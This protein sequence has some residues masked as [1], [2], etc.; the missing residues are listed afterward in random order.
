ITAARDL[1][2]GLIGVD[3]NEFEEKREVHRLSSGLQ[4]EQGRDK[5][6]SSTSPD[7]AEKSDSS[8]VMVDTAGDM[9]D[10][11]DEDK[12]V[13]ER[14]I[15]GQGEGK[16][17][18]FSKWLLV[19]AFTR[20]LRNPPGMYAVIDTSGGKTSDYSEAPRHGTVPTTCEHE[21]APCPVPG[22]YAL[23]A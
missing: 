3:G 22:H 15:E 5:G 16:D 4:E 8:F 1:A 10:S 11:S 14:D 2:T 12:K 6:R 20:F 21:F 17:C 19:R 7:E 18:A 23:L 9:Q 13:L